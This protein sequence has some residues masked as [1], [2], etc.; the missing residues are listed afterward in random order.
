MAVKDLLSVEEA[1]TCCWYSGLLMSVIMLIIVLAWSI[2]YHMGVWGGV[3][4]YL[5]LN[6]ELY[7]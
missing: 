4:L 3:R 7:H 2:I 1:C 6:E 5:V